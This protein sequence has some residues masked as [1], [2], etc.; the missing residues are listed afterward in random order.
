[1]AILEKVVTVPM[2]GDDK[3]KVFVI[4]RMNAFAADKWGRHVMQA[5]ISSGADLAGLN[6]D[7]GLAGVAAAGINIFG[8][9]D[10]TKTDVL[11]DQLMKCI[12]VQPDPN[13]AA[14]RR[15]LHETDIV[16]IE[17]VGWLQKEAFSLHVGFFKGVSRLFSLLY[18]MLGTPDQSAQSPEPRT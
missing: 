11:L 8:I 12:T 6:A 16:E 18:L 14:I 17:T 13:N 10:P 7:D 1:M 9:M 15:P 5:A 2:D 4:T 3:G